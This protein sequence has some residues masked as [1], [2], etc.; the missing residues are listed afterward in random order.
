MRSKKKKKKNQCLPTTLSLM[1]I[2]IDKK[3]SPSSHPSCCWDVLHP[4]AL[5]SS[6]VLL[7]LSACGVVGVWYHEECRSK[8]GLKGPDTAMYQWRDCRFVKSLP[9]SFNQLSCKLHKRDTWQDRAGLSVNKRPMQTTTTLARS[10]VLF[11]SHTVTH[12]HTNI[13]NQLLITE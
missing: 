9:N 7:V 6:V 3:M 2:Y 5:F 13:M 4:K 11:H 8:F 12:T 1:W 10:L